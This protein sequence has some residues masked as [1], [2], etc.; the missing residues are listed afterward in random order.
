MKKYDYIAVDFDGTV[1][2][3]TRRMGTG[4]GNVPMVM[5]AIGFNCLQDPVPME[6]KPPCITQGNNKDRKIYIEM[7]IPTNENGFILFDACFK[8]CEEKA[9]QLIKEPFRPINFV[10]LENIKEV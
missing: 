5:E 4:G 6:N 3:L 1:Q 7:D 2:T 9:K 10:I 8:Q